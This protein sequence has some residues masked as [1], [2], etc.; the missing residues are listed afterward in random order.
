MKTLIV[1]PAFN[2]EATIIPL[3]REIQKHSSDILIVDDGSS[4]KTSILCAN[5]KVSLIKHQ[6]NLGLSRAMYTAFN[7]ARENSFTHVLAMDSD[8]QH[9]PKYIPDFIELGKKSDLVYSNRFHD[10]ALIPSVKIASNLFASSLAEEILNKFVADVSCGF[11]LYRID[12][13]KDLDF[14][15]KL[16][17][18]YSSLF[19][20][21]KNKLQINSCKIEAIYNSDQ[22]LSTSRSEI[23]SLV[24]SLESI[25]AN[26]KLT[27]LNFQINSALDFKINVKDVDFFGF[28]LERNNSYLIQCDLKT[29]TRKYNQH[30]NSSLHPCS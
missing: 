20:S 30:E 5:L 28:Y 8:N 6:N 13:F 17:F 25:C 14:G 22:L 15:N 27:E 26:K 23:L 21:I 2:S 1:V 18:V 24:N 10:I 9:D 7:F 29:A 16:E 19:F 4:D 3:L 11:R 12:A